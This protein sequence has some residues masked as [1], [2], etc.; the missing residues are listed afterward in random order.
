[1]KPGL[2]LG[3]FL[4]AAAGVPFARASVG[5]PLT[6]E[7]LGWDPSTERIYARQV[8]HD[9]SGDKNCTFYYDLRSATPGRPLVVR[10]SRLG[11]AWLADTTGLALQRARLER[12]VQHLKPLVRDEVDL[13]SRIRHARVVDTRIVTKGCVPEPTQ[14]F[15]VDIAD[16]SADS[17]QDSILVTTY[18]EPG[19]HR[20]RRYRIPDRE[21]RLVVVAYVGDPY[22]GGYEVQRCVLIGLAGAGIQRLD[23]SHGVLPCP[24]AH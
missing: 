8:G 14:R 12:T 7:V 2:A 9:E 17:A 21:S 11:W 4:F 19:V 16:Y 1:V 3:A 6:V 13:E 10:A 23:S 22:E 5:G 24:L 15:V 20:I 18:L